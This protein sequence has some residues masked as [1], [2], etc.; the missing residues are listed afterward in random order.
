MPASWV[1]AGGALL[2]GLSAYKGSKQAGNTTQTQQQQLDPRMQAYLYGDGTDGNRGILSQVAG[3]ANQPQSQAQSQFG[4]GVN[5]YLYNYGAPNLIDSQKTA[6]QLQS[7]N[8]NAPQMNTANAVR[9]A[10]MVSAQAAGTQINA[11]AQ[12]SLNL[13]GAYDKFIN[14]DAG[15]NPYLTGALKSAVDLTNTSYQNNQDSLT[16]NLQRNILPGLRSSA[17]LTGQY[18]G[19]RQGIAEGNAIS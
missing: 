4:N 18:G 9:P 1:A 17:V 2:G 19:S 7:S 12:N 8:I 6:Q 10:D 16:N 11:P 15:A 13:S 5:S 3:I 14:G